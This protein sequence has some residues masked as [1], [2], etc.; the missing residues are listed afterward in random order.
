RK[1]NGKVRLPFSSRTVARV[2]LVLVNAN[3]AFSRCWVN[4]A[5]SCSGIPAK[6]GVKET[7]SAKVS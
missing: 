2:E 7:L 1:G 4:T 5:Y 3:H 6:D